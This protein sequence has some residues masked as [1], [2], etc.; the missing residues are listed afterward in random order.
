MSS[1]TTS[2]SPLQGLLLLAVLGLCGWSGWLT[3]ENQNLKKVIGQSGGGGNELAGKVASLEETIENGLVLSLIDP[4]RGN[5]LL[6]QAVRPVSVDA[7]NEGGASTRKPAFGLGRPA[8]RSTV[9]SDDPNEPFDF[10][11]GE[12][13]TTDDVSPA[14]AEDMIDGFQGGASFLDPG[15]P[16]VA[17]ID[18]LGPDSFGPSDPDKSGPD[19]FGPD[20]F[21]SDDF[22]PDNFG[23]TPAP[24]G[25]VSSREPP[26]S[27]GTFGTSQNLLDG[28]DDNYLY[29]LTI[30]EVQDNGFIGL[31]GGSGSGVKVGA[32]F[33]VMRGNREIGKVRVQE[34]SD[35]RSIGEIA[36]YVGG[37]SIRKGD[38]VVPL[39]N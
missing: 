7:T 29:E 5:T 26:P 37:V 38:R 11:S 33:A 13:E 25:T 30:L 4:S 19:D 24:E 2:K 9:E 10:S 20:D 17:S 16:G 23:P 32:M 28:G 6:T 27:T 21:G 31:D 14:P 18:D 35:S 22:G 15:Q 1:A 39:R 36:E 12:D 34:L 8:P 3:M